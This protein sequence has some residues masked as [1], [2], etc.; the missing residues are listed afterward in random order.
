MLRN[1]RESAASLLARLKGVDG[2]SSG[3]DADL[4]DGVQ[5]ASYARLDQA[6]T[7]AAGQ[8][9][10]GDL[11]LLYI[12]AINVQRTIPTTVGDAVDI[13]SFTLTNGSGNLELY[14]TVPSIG[15]S[16]CKRYFIT[17]KYNGTANVWQRVAAVSSTG[18]YN[19]TENVDLE[20]N[21]NNAV[22]SFRL[23]RTQGTVAGTASI[24]IFH[25]G[26]V[27]DTFTPSTAVA[28]VA[29]PT[30]TYANFA[31]TLMLGA[32]VE[33][34]GT[35]STTNWNGTGVPVRLF[36][37]SPTGNGGSTP[38]TP[39]TVFVLGRDGVSG[40]AYGNMVECKVSRYENSGVNSRTAL[41]FALM[42]GTPSG[43][44]TTVM[45]LRSDGS[46]GIGTTDQFGTGAKVIGIANAT[47]APT[48]NPTAGG[49]LYAEA[50]ALKWRGSAGTVTT[51]AAA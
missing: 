28:T 3:L 15:Y 16:Q 27:A 18:P 43:T 31:D 13:G 11:T 14:V 40:Q 12:R 33:Q 29:A 37:K 50:G 48:T 49:V 38:A 9:I 20:I 6:N 5:G 7:F 2:A 42:H 46:V 17:A 41:D 26:V 23:R 21:S 35:W 32:E 39:E 4:L 24:T 44:G 25:Q 1:L 36:A 10:S 47:T 34:V 22:T 8:T 19:A 45:R 51:I 30:V